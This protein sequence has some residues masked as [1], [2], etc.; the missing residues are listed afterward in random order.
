[1][2]MY[3]APFGQIINLN[4]GKIMKYIFLVL[5]LLVPQSAINA[6]NFALNRYQAR[7]VGMCALAFGVV[8]AWVGLAV[9]ARTY[10][11]E[12]SFKNLTFMEKIQAFKW[13][14]IIAGLAGGAIAGGSFAYSGHVMDNAINSYYNA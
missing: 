13:H 4:L 3:M 6:N 11:D 14:Y 2:V 12:Y 5:M 8:S 9:A 10:S 1:M 7:D